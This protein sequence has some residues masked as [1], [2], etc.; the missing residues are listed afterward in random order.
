M[1][2]QESREEPQKEV[3]STIVKPISGVP[4][5]DIA[6]DISDI[7]DS[8]VGESQFYIKNTSIRYSSD[9][10]HEEQEEQEEE[11]Y[12]HDHIFVEDIS[13]TRSGYKKRVTTCTTVV[14]PHT[15]ATKAEDS[16]DEEEENRKRETIVSKAKVPMATRTVV[17]CLYRPRSRTEESCS[18]TYTTTVSSDSDQNASSCTEDSA[19]I[20]Q[21]PSLVSRYTHVQRQRSGS[22]LTSTGDDSDQHTDNEQLFRRPRSESLSSESS[23]S[24]MYEGEGGVMREYVPKNFD[25]FIVTDHFPNKLLMIWPDGDRTRKCSMSCR[26]LYE[27]ARLMQNLSK[28][29]PQTINVQFG[30]TITTELYIPKCKL[31]QLIPV[32]VHDPSW[33]HQQDFADKK[34]LK[35]EPLILLVIDTSVYIMDCRG[36]KSR[37]YRM[38]EL[39][40]SVPREDVKKKRT[41]RGK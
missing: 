13:S 23:V 31:V 36:N 29:Q 40:I 11:H 33:L 34:T 1:G 39:T 21:T 7:D 24:N 32:V 37:D 6:I 20:Q 28:I 8:G 9:D 5:V 10:G 38:R 3:S 2:N 25:T 22:I 17:P 41:S 15:A 18:N 14:L 27:G 30:A 19:S 35:D 16:E 12:G 26:G 4:N